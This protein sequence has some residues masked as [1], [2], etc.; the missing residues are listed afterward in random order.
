MASEAHSDAGVKEQ[1]PCGVSFCRWN[2]AEASVQ[3]IHEMIHNRA[4]PMCICRLDDSWPGGPS[5][6]KCGMRSC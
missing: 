3:C 2:V 5:L 1:Q 6:R 4:I